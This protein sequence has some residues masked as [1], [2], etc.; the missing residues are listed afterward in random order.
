MI[1][2]EPLFLRQTLAGFVDCWKLFGTIYD[3]IS[4]KL[5]SHTSRAC[6]KASKAEK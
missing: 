2:P 4:N 1:L 6:Q 5:A 3:V